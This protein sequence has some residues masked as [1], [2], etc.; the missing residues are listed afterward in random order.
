MAFEF[1]IQRP[2]KRDKLPQKQLENNDFFP[3]FKRGFQ[4]NNPKKEFLIV[5]LVVA[6]IF[7][8]MMNLFFSNFWNSHSKFNFVFLV[9]IAFLAFMLILVY[10]SE[11]NKENKNTLHTMF[12]SV[13]ERQYSSQLIDS[14]QNTLDFSS[15][16]QL[17]SFP[18]FCPHCGVRISNYSYLENPD[19]PP[20]FCPFCGESL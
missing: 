16:K 5:S 20:K 15:A 4:N 1:N 8:I 18:N 10:Y 19:E 6:I 9:Y 14:N 17:Q 13:L 7:W 11:Q 3:A 12:Y 2:Y